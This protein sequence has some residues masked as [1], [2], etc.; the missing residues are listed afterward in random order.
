MYP[1]GCGVPKALKLGLTGAALPDLAVVPKASK[2]LAEEAPPNG[3]KADGFCTGVVDT[4]VGD[5]NGSNP[6]DGPFCTA[7]A[8]DCA[9]GELKGSA[10]W[11]V[12]A[13][14]V[15]GDGDANGSKVAEVFDIPERKGSSCTALVGVAEAE[16]FILRRSMPKESPVGVAPAEALRRLLLP[17]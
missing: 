17:G 9:D 16:S 14:F 6:V 12:K 15:A 1:G 4:A 7:I 8:L 3:S 11:L 10:D 5:P 2:V 13:P